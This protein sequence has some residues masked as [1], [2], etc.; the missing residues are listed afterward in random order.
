MLSFRLSINWINCC[1]TAL[2]NSFDKQHW[3]EIGLKSE[4]CVGCMIFG[5]GTTRE[6]FHDSGYLFANMYELIIWV[7]G[8]ARWFDKSLMCFAGIPSLPVES[9]FRIC[10]RSDNVSSYVIGCSLNRSFWVS[11]LFAIDSSM[12]FVGIGITF[13]VRFP[14]VAKNSFSSFGSFAIILLGGFRILCINRHGSFVFLLESAILKKF[15]FANRIFL[16][17]SARAL[18]NCC[19][20]WESLSRWHWYLQLLRD[21]FNSTISGSFIHG[22]GGRVILTRLSGAWRSMQSRSILLRV[23]SWSSGSSNAYIALKG[24]VSASWRNAFLSKRF[25][26]R[27]YL[28]RGSN[29]GDFT[30]I[31]AYGASWS[32][33]NSHGRT[34]VRVMSDFLEVIMWSMSVADCSVIRVGLDT[35]WCRSNCSSRLQYRRTVGF[36]GPED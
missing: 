19:H 36:L 22:A 12:M 7:T 18:L 11:V 32:L 1:R 13:V 4:S 16:L 20:E 3:T 21:F 15:L 26:S 10:F 35:I 28:K 34:S 6:S 31:V 5:I 24:S 17:I 14:V 30:L 9:S 2:S 8:D 27:M 29:F 23:Y 33:I 25:S